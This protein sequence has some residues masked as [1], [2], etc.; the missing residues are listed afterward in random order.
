M[1]FSC[2]LHVSFPKFIQ[3]RSCYTH[4]TVLARENAKHEREDL[5]VIILIKRARQGFTQTFRKGKHR[6]RRLVVLPKLMDVWNV[7]HSLSQLVWKMSSFTLSLSFSFSMTCHCLIWQASIQSRP[8]IPRQV[9]SVI[10]QMVVVEVGAGYW[11]QKMVRYR[12]PPL[13]SFEFA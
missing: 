1:A 13:V 4:E 7:A 11:E 5:W 10:C 2:F 12:I 9:N 3:L 8:R 6:G